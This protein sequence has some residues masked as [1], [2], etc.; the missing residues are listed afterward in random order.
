MS[1][2]CFNCSKHLPPLSTMWKKAAKLL[3]LQEGEKAPEE[4]KTKQQL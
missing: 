3:S 2:K 4:V 1:L